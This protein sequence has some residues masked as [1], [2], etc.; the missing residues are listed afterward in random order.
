[1]QTDYYEILKQEL[2][3]KTRFFCQNN[4][5]FQTEI[6]ALSFYKE[7][8]PTEFLSM[9]YEPSLCLAI[10]GT[11]AV[12]L[13]TDL[14]EYDLSSYLLA[15]VHTPARVRVK[16]ASPAAPYLGLKIAFSLE[17]V[18]DIIH[19]MDGNTSTK[20]SKNGLYFGKMKISLLDAIVRLIR[21]IEKPHDRKI[22]MPLIIKEIL[23]LVMQEEGG[24]FIR[25]YVQDGKIAHQVVK[26]ISQIKN[27]FRENLNVRIL[28]HSVGMSESSLYHHFKKMTTMS[29]LQFQKTLR[30][31]EARQKLLM[32]KMEISK[33]AFDVGYE[34]PSQF[35]REYTRMFGLPPKMD[36]K[37]A[38][39]F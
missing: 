18:F 5:S 30:L 21:L 32:Q 7:T 20:N 23:Y 4:G 29:P 10:Q 12:G 28:A 15:S 22:L 3:E 25:R 33:I 13:G 19:E 27:H 1:M 17:Q 14:F 2:I 39:P 36:A 16:Q 8:Q 24:D 35:S 34:S 37:K 11:K 31:Q 6:D 26:A 9:I 38:I